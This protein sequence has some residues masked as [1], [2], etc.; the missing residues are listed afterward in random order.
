MLSKSPLP[1]LSVHPLTHNP[2]YLKLNFSL[3]RNLNWFQSFGIPCHSCRLF[4]CFKDSKVAKLQAVAF[5]KFTD[6]LVEEL[7]DYRFDQYLFA[8][9]LRR[10]T[11]DKILFCYCWYSVALQ[12]YCVGP[13]SISWKLQ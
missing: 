4:S 9:C 3:W 1:H 12:L 10:D 13:N 8:L 2:P 7:L 6:D 11:V 5:D